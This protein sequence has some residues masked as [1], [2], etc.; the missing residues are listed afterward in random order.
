MNQQNKE[1]KK[2]RGPKFTPP[3]EFR[4]PSNTTHSA[5]S[6]SLEAQAAHRNDIK[7]E[8]RKSAANPRY[9]P[10]MEIGKRFKRFFDEQVIEAR[11]KAKQKK[12]RNNNVKEEK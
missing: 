12:K 11:H 7:E 3:Q 2:P 8:A 5:W 6:R 1:E 4:A 10:K 9:T